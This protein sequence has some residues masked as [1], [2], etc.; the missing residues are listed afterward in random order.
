MLIRSIS[1]F[2]NKSQEDLIFED[3]LDFYRAINRDIE[4]DFNCAHFERWRK[5]ND[6]LTF[7]GFSQYSFLEHYLK[8]A[9]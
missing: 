8:N 9:A 1:Q 7:F 6:S 3:A 4:G 2:S 5:N